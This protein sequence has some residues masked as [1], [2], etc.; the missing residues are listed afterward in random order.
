MQSAANVKRNGSP[1]GIAVRSQGGRRGYPSC[2]SMA[3]GRMRSGAA[4]RI[5]SKGSEVMSN[6]SAHEGINQRQEPRYRGQFR[7]ITWR[8]AGGQPTPGLLSDFSES[9]A[10]FM[11][12]QRVAEK[13]N[14]GEE[15]ILKY[16][17]PSSEIHIYQVRHVERIGFGFLLAG[18]CRTTESNELNDVNVTPS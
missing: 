14:P 3:D 16:A 1:Q 15:I 13:V 12:S 10:S 17:A 9:G 11:I 4:M 18:C 8:K 5:D 7:Q 6:T 2:R